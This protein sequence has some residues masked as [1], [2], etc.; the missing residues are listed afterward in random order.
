MK[1]AEEMLKWFK[2]VR[3]INRSQLSDTLSRG[4]FEQIEEGLDTD[5]IYWIRR[6]KIYILVY[7]MG[8]L[9]QIISNSYYR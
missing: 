5:C 3:K 9:W 8:F 4:L 1:T 6:R 2:I 7:A